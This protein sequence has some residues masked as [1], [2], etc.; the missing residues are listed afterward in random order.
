MY[1]AYSSNMMN[2]P[3]SFSD[4]LHG[5]KAESGKKHGTNKAA[6]GHEE[7]MTKKEV[8]IFIEKSNMELE[9]FTPP[10]QGGE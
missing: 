7:F 5:I 3:I 6:S 2:E 4:Y 8:E 1:L 10:M 9:N